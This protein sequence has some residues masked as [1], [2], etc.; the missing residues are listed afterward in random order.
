[1]LLRELQQYLLEYI[2]KDWAVSPELISSKEAVKFYKKHG[3]EE[4]NAL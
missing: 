1:M 2:G 3:F 4:S